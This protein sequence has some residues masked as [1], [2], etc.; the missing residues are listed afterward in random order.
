M[1]Q[2]RADRAALGRLRLEL[3]PGE[4]RDF[5]EE[6]L[7]SPPEPSGVARHLGGCHRVEVARELGDPD[8]PA[9]L[10]ELCDARSH[11]RACHDL[12]AVAAERGDKGPD[13]GWR[14]P[15]G[16]VHGPRVHDAAEQ[17]GD[18]DKRALVL[19][20]RLDEEV[21][22]LRHALACIAPRTRR[23]SAFGAMKSRNMIP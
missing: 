19:G 10:G 14:R 8:E 21:V 15:D 2:D 18:V 7:A 5:P 6:V 16:V 9:L 12:L 22:R 13:H 1:L 3:L 17:L 11:G 4:A 20:T 23:E